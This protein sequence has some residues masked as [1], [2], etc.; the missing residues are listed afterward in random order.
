MSHQFG[1]AEAVDRQE[2][3]DLRA[4]YGDGLL[5]RVDLDIDEPLYR[6]RTEKATDRRAEVVFAIRGPGG[7]VLV[8]RKTFWEDG[9]YRLPSGGINPCEPV[10]DAL[11]RELHEETSLV[12]EEILFLGAQ[13]CHLHYGSHTCRFVSYVFHVP[14]TTGHLVPEEKEEI[15]EFRELRPD[16]LAALAVR[17]RHLD[18]PYAGWGRWR[19]VAH[20]LVYRRLSVENGH[21]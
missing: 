21:S 12:A 20:D 15:A 17:L 11:M 8:H 4:R 3:K 18:P 13:D 2:F 6:I 9:L 7:G 19:A 1:R 5:E 16:G 14:R 10:I